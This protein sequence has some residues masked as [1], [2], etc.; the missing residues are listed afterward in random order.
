MLNG[1]WKRY[2]NDVIA[3]AAFGIQVNSFKDPNNEFFTLGQRISE[4]TLW[5]GFKV[6]L[7]ILVPKLMKVRFQRTIK[8]L[9]L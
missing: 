8:S 7:Y 2:T 5:G 4:F 6:V 9:N 1:N 3:T